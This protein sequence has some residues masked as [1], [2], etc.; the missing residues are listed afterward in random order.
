M[1]WFNISYD[2][3]KGF[4]ADSIESRSDFLLSDLF[5][6]LLTMRWRLNEGAYSWLGCGEL[7]RFWLFCLSFLDDMT[8][9]MLPTF[10]YGFLKLVEN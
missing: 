1:S 5:D 9:F 10:L 3:D 6:A 2:Y 4:C 8:T 7:D